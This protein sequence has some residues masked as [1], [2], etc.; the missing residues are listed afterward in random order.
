MNQKDAEAQ[1]A[2]ILAA[3]QVKYDEAAAIA[4]EANVYFGWEG[5]NH[6]YG[7]GGTYTPRQMCIEEN[8]IEDEEDLP[9]DDETGEYNGWHASSD[10]Y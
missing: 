10:N 6:T 8:E 5:P 7:A 3:I 9:V 2:A 4:E 1:I